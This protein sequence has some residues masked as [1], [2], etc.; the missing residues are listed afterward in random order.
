MPLLSLLSLTRELTCHN[1]EHSKSLDDRRCGPDNGRLLIQ[2]CVKKK[3][4]FWYRARLCI[5]HTNTYTVYVNVTHIYVYISVSQ[6]LPTY[7]FMYPVCHA[8]GY[9]T[10]HVNKFHMSCHMCGVSTVTT[11]PYT[12]MMCY[13]IF[14]CFPVTFGGPCF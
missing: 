7:V 2:S 13:D 12:S 1:M 10:P 14:A 11:K 5:L 4:R 6:S 3:T 9:H 8:S